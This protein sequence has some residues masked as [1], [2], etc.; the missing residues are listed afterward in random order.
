MFVNYFCLVTLVESAR[1]ELE[2]FQHCISFTITSVFFVFL[3]RSIASFS[4]ANSELGFVTHA[5]DGMILGSTP[6]PKLAEYPS[7]EII[8]MCSM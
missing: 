1:V 2:R 5:L 7:V 3:V 6:V 8:N 4:A